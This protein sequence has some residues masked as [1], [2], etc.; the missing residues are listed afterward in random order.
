MRFADEAL[1]LGGE[2]LF[3]KIDGHF[4]RVGKVDYRIMDDER[5]IAAI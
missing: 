2:S 3:D 5:V 1:G 4:A